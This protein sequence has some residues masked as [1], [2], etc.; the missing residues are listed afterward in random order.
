MVRRKCREPPEPFAYDIERAIA[1]E[2]PLAALAADD[3]AE[4]EVAVANLRFDGDASGER[5]GVKGAG[6]RN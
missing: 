5:T 1:I 6:H 3:G 2:Q 4:A